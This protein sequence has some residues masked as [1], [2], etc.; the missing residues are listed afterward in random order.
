MK[1][2]FGLV[3]LVITFILF[4]GCAKIEN[5]P[6]VSKI[7]NSQ[8][9]EINVNEGF[10]PKVLGKIRSSQLTELYLYDGI[11]KAAEYSLSQGYTHF[12]VLNE[13]INNFEGFPISNY[14]DLRSYC[15]SYKVESKFYHGSTS[16][17]CKN[18]SEAGRETIT[19]RI[20]PINEMEN[21]FSWNAKEVLAEL[22]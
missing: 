3:A 20:L 2:M 17:K 13:G 22:K 19:L 11:K 21:V 16:G 9:V 14:Q 4:S 8:V 1:K 10:S 6:V 15:F 18:I 7:E 12:V 5:V